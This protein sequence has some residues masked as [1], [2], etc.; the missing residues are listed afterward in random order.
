VLSPSQARRLAALLRKHETVT[1]KAVVDSKTYDGE[2]DTITGVLPG[3]EAR[4]ITLLG[5]IYEPFVPDDATAAAAII[6]IGRLLSRLTAEGALPPL[7]RT[8][9]LLLGME[10]YGMACFFADEARRAATLTAVNMDAICYDPHATG[11]PVTVCMSPH[12]LPFAGDFLLRE[13]A[14]AALADYPWR[15]TYK[16]ADNDNFLSDSAIGIPTSWVVAPPGKLHH[17]SRDCL[18]RLV[19]W[20]LAYRVTC[21]VGAYAYALAT[22]DGD[23][24]SRLLRL[25]SRGARMEILRQAEALDEAVRRG[26]LDG[27]IAA[28][29][30][31]RHAEWQQ[32]RT[33]SM[34]RIEAGVDTGG[35]CLEIEVLAEA[36]CR[37][38]AASKPAAK[39]ALSK[40]ERAAKN[41]VV[42]RVGV[43]FPA[44]EARV[45]PA[46]RFLHI[47]GKYEIL[48]WC[49]GERDL[50]E[51]LALCECETG[52][53]VGDE[54]IE[55][56]LH[57]ME[58]LERYGYVELTYRKRPS[59]GSAA[60]NVTEAPCNHPRET[61][62]KKRD[63]H[64]SR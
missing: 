48:N 46:E 40:W 17:N 37:R 11:V 22:V 8:V 14:E 28:E 39:R 59:A 25:V 12:A 50:L 7:K 36:E 30:L 52:R 45:P 24:L 42:R 44:S 16:W 56:V 29:R 21:L 51:A 62:S 27:A 38:F 60:A 55:R 15:A 49:N 3:R 41:T 2:I 34:R 63:G 33:R 18:D 5:H 19:D 31:H 1:L 13:M 57:Y 35:A 9:R 61:R 23:D 53:E 43:W 32:E 20:E 54:D 26:E 6:E 4:E 10:Q 58:Q 64:E 47:A